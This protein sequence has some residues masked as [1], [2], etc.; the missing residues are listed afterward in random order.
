MPDGSTPP[1][2]PAPLEKFWCKIGE[3]SKLVGV[4]P[5]VLRFWESSISAIRP[6][7]SRKGQR[8]YSRRD[9]ELLKTIRHLLYVEGYT[10]DGARRR[11][12]T[13][14]ACPHCGK[15]LGDGEHGAPSGT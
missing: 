6:R 14:K 13:A 12:K 10:I 1:P 2:A 9:V 15:E 3:V 4:E 5:H 11:L 8:V 7:K